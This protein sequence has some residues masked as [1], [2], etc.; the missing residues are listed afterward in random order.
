M[1][2]IRIG[3]F[4]DWF[5]DADPE[6]VSACRRAV[7]AR[8]ARGATVVG[9]SVPH[10]NWLSLSHSI[11]IATE[12]A[13]AFDK[14]YHQNWADLET[15]TRITVAL[16]KSM[17]ALEVLAAEKLRGWAFDYM[18]QLFETHAL[19]AIANPTVGMLAP[20]LT[21]D[22]KLFGESNSPLVLQMMK[23][24]NMGNFLGMSAAV[25]VCCYTAAQS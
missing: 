8:E 10:L 16:G 13:L 14:N 24:I 17:S 6:V 3:I 22:A 25:P 18:H 9:I 2:D 11:K 12:F 19:S 5:N 1:S 23:Y 7:A 21:E 20:P 4:D 15:N